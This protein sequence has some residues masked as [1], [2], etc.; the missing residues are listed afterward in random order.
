MTF[1][2]INTIRAW[3][4]QPHGLNKALNMLQ[5]ELQPPAVAAKKFQFS[6]AQHSQPK[7]QSAAAQFI[8]SLENSQPQ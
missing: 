2:K 6:F 1:H 4:S 7:Q 3:Q 8:L 5:P